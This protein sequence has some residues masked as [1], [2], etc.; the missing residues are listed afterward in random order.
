MDF[1]KET[2]FNGIYSIEPGTYGVF[3]NNKIILKKYWKLE[4][5]KK[6]F[7]QKSTFK[8]SDH[9]D[10]LLKNLLINILFLKKNW[11]I[12]KWRNR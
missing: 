12:L 4:N 11:I 6:N 8:N 9:L 10:I 5:S 2:F 3:K 7:N 1:D